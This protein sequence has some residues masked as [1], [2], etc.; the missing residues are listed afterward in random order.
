MTSFLRLAVLSTIGALISCV[1]GGYGRRVK[2][3]DVEVEEWKE[4]LGRKMKQL[5]LEGSCNDTEDA[6][7]KA[8][9]AANEICGFDENGNPVSPPGEL[10]VTAFTND[11]FYCVDNRF[12]AII[13]GF[14]APAG[15]MHNAPQVLFEG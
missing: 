4:D 5:T 6:R 11:S 1:G 9:F 7:L 3:G 15:R 2:F 14:C 8:L 13:F 10:H 12:R